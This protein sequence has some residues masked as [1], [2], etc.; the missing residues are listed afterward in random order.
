MHC[1][2]CKH[3]CNVCRRRRD[4]HRHRH[5]HS[6]RHLF[7]LHLHSHRPWHLC[8]LVHWD[9]SV[10]DRHQNCVRRRHHHRQ[11]PRAHIG[12]GDWLQ[13]S[14][15]PA[16]WMIRRR[17]RPHDQSYCQRY[18]LS[19]C[20]LQRFAKYPLP[21]GMNDPASWLHNRLFYLRGFHLV[22]Q[23]HPGGTSRSWGQCSF[24]RLGQHRKI[25][26]GLVGS[27]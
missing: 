1:C 17:R 12:P 27:N 19:Q 20:L 4:N 2:H 7:H 10:P 25:T 15:A 9:Q 8:C 21:E 3:H 11:R 24:E 26:S 16:R 5:R 23:W 18:S 14:C 6:G 22:H 13:P